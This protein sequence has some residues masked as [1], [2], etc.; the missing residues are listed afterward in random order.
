MLANWLR[1]RTEE[2]EVGGQR[3]KDKPAPKAEMTERQERERRRLAFAPLV[4]ERLND[5]TRSSDR[6][7]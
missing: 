3:Q 7:A 1:Y 5:K 2:S 6:A 4:Q